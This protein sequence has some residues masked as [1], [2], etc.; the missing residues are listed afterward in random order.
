MGAIF[1]A[2]KFVSEKI[3]ELRKQIKGKAVVA[4]SGGVD[5]SSCALL[6][7]KAIGKDLVP[8]FIDDG[9]MREDEGKKVVRAFKAF[10]V[11]VRVINAAKRFFKAL[12]GKADPEQKRK[13]FREV[14]Y[15]VLGEV[16]RKNKASF[17]IQG[18]IAADVLET[19]KGIKTQHNVLTQIGINTKKYGFKVIEPLK[20][21]FKPQVRQVA[22]AL[23]FSKKFFEKMP[24]P[25]PGL[26]TRVVGEVT[27]AK[28]RVVRKATRIIEEEIERARLKPFQAF[29]VLLSE[30]ATGLKKGKRAFGQIIVLRSV[31]SRNALT[32]SVTRIPFN[33][34]QKIQVRIT[35]E[36][37][38]V[39]KVVY[40]ITPKPPS[41]IEF[42]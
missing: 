34:L 36:I 14:F 2:K 33:I 37:P 16:T 25:G 13:A 21:L 38:S 11:K 12:K 7:F 5:S 9:L 3:V 22:Q 17:L 28:I 8:V 15:Q 23:G 40:D 19:R 42:I 30:K 35:R 39:T 20:T 1:K 32:A 6:A 31:E 18:T 41:T 26:A 27:P 24:F 4:L 10:G 29:A